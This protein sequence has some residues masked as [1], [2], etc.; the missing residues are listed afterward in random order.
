[1]Y[2]VY[3][4]NKAKYMDLVGGSRAKRGGSGS[5]RSEPTFLFIHVQP[6]EVIEDYDLPAIVSNLKSYGKVYEYTSVFAKTG[7]IYKLEDLS[8]SSVA[9]DIASYIKSN[10]LGKVYLIT[11][12]HGGPYGLYF[13]TKY[14]DMCEGVICF[15]LRLYSKS[16]LER[17][18]WKF[19]ER[20]GFKKYTSK[21]YDVDRHLINITD[22]ALDELLND[23]SDEARE[24][25]YLIFDF[26]MHRQADDIP[27][28]FSV[29]TYLF[30][31]LDLDIDSIVKLNFERK[32]IADMKKIT[33][34]GDALYNSMMW[35]FHRI[36]FDVELQ[37]QNSS[38]S[39]LTIHYMVGGINK[40]PTLIDA[41][42][43]MLYK[44]CGV[45]EI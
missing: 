6:G 43:V 29:P 12:S 7:T 16:S 1:M 33:S 45:S 24:V 4:T 37:K 8:F 36:Q 15:P 18:I 32:D 27:K 9:K 20:E 22:E 41:V 44:V 3:Q 31:R 19:K 25:L 42:K 14:A 30:S 35:N 23:N 34:E 11:V 39:N 28:V 17:R 13:S 21:K 40:W 10:N 5:D 26:N 38:N 2:G